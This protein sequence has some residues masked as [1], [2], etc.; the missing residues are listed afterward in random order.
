MTC[1]LGILWV[2]AT[3]YKHSQRS[4]FKNFYMNAA[5]LCTTRQHLHTNSQKS[6][7]L[8]KVHTSRISTKTRP[9][10]LWLDSI[11]IRIFDSLRFSTASLLQKSIHAGPIKQSSWFLKLVVAKFF[12]SQPHVYLYT[13]F[14]ISFI[15][16]YLLIDWAG[17]RTLRVNS[18]RMIWGGYD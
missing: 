11:E 12:K 4:T 3:L 10:S 8:K 1:N 5:W 13:H 14:W 18:L 6:N 2:F 16:I 9:G 15:H 7:I 17:R